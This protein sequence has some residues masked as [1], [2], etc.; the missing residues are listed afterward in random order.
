[1]GIA[2]WLVI[3]VV[4]ALVIGRLFHLREKAIGQDRPPMPVRRIRPAGPQAA[5]DA[6]PYVDE[7][8]PDAGRELVGRPVPRIPQQR[9][10]VPRTRRPRIGPSTRRG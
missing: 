8:P 3:A 10:P 6:P 2:G 4:A 9:R 7:T 1:M 5:Q